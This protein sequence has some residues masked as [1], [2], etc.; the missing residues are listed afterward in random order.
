MKI[1]LFLTVGMLLGSHSVANEALAKKNGCT[2]CHAMASTLVG[3]AFNDV[4]AKYADQSDAKDQL[5]QSIR[6]GGTGK[7]GQM[8][9]PPQTQL[10]VSDAQKL[11]AWVLKSK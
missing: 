3:P 4:A 6:Q 5:V 11:A 1:A 8:V 10:S 7:W 2:G 9:M